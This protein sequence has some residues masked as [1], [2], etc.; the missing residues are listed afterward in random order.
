VQADVVEAG[1]GRRDQ[2]GG[3]YHR[4]ATS[5]FR[6]VPHF[7]KM[8]YDN[9]QLLALYA[10]LGADGSAL[11]ERVAR[12]TADWMI[13][14]L[15]TPEGGFASALDADTEGEEGRFYVWTP[16]QL[17]EVL[18]EE[19]GA[20]AA[21]VFE[22]TSEGTFEHGTS[23]LQ[24]RHEPGG[25]GAQ[26]LV[27]VRRRL[28]EARAERVAPARDDKVVAAW[29]GLAISGLVAAGLLLAERSYVDRAVAAGELLVRVHLADGT[30]LLRVSRDGVA[31]RHAGVLED[32]G[33]VATGFLDLLQA[34][35]DPVWLERATA[36]LD[37]ALELFRADDG[38]FFDTASD[39]ET[40][41]ARPRDPSDNASP[42]GLSST[43]HALVNAHAVTG[44]GRYRQAAEEALATVSGLMERAPRF[45]GWSLAAALTMADG[46]REVAVVGPA[47]PERDALAA[48][49][50]RLPGAVVLVA[51]GPSADIPLLDGRIPV[52]GRPAAYVCRGFVCE[53]PVTTPD[54]L[55]ATP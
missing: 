10:R 39:A 50:R 43:V 2:L 13:R 4:Y 7:E 11:G 20:W 3:G 51:D 55:V 12:E 44:E 23:T 35:G 1:T 16:A 46:P 53:R 14:E 31:G 25:P 42:S 18:G 37:T 34:T 41:V 47:G 17:V 33:C 38:G 30:R 8:L 15:S 49:A 48:A 36:L 5:R 22:V 27:D 52:D 32:Y 26:R 40:L 54:A 21:E 28:L 29:N 24:L 45:A 19:D 9:A 6:I